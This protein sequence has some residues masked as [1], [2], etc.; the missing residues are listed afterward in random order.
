MDT[1][2]KMASRY[3]FN[4]QEHACFWV[5]CCYSNWLTENAFVCDA[6]EG[7][8]GGESGERGGKSVGLTR[9]LRGGG[10]DQ[11][12]PNWAVCV[13]VHV[14]YVC[15]HVCVMCVQGWRWKERRGGVKHTH[16]ENTQRLLTVFGYCWSRTSPTRLAHGASTWHWTSGTAWT[17]RTTREVWNNS[18]VASF[19]PS[20]LAR[21]DLWVRGSSLSW[22]QSLSSYSS[23][24]SL[25]GLFSLFNLLCV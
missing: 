25:Y 12:R 5:L 1:W 11:R 20:C 3:C 9:Y 15:A 8:C 10:R 7:V 16:I 2:L 18:H 14:C 24:F 21:Y 22:C 6:A 17:Q 13:C 4:L 19:T 23:V